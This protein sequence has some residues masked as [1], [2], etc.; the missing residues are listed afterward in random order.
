MAHTHGAQ[1]IGS[2][3]HVFEWF[4]VDGPVE[5]TMGDRFFLEWPF[6]HAE[7]FQLFA[8]AFAQAFPDT[9]IIPTSGLCPRD[10]AA[11]VPDLPRHDE[12]PLQ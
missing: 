9:L 3:Q 2:G 7:M 4:Y 12:P 6:L 8:K 11:A 1:P 10:T 5:S